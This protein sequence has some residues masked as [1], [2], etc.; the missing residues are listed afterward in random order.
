MGRISLLGTTV[1][2]IPNGYS[3]LDLFR[4]SAADTRS[5]V[6][7]Q[8]A[9]ASSDSGHTN[10]DYFNAT[11]GGDWGDWSSSGLTSAG[12]DA[13]DAFA[14]AGTQYSISPTDTSLMNMLG[15]HLP[16]A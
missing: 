10:L 5:L 7:G 14:A 3:T 16:L 2:G 4:Y 11:A 6:G 12:N 15:Y 1:D 8:T 9:Y 13:Y